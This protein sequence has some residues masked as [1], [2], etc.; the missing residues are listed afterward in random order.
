[1]RWFCSVSSVPVLGLVC[2][3]TATSCISSPAYD[4]AETV[5]PLDG[6]L[7]QSKPVAN[8]NEPNAAVGYEELSAYYGFK[9]IEIVK[10]DYNIK[11]LRTADF[12][13]DGRIDIAL[14]NN[15]KAAIEL[16]LQKAG[17]S[18]EEN[19]PVLSED[20]DVNRL[21][22]PSRFRR[23]TVPV[24][25]KIYCL[26]CGDLNS[27]GL[28]D[29]AFYGEPR[30]LYV[31]LQKP[32]PAEGEKAKSLSW[33]RR[34][35]IEINDGLVTSG[36]LVCA[37][38][39]NDGRADLALAGREAVYLITQKEDG[40]LAEPV[41]YATTSLVKEIATGDLNG[42][43]LNDLVTL[44][45]EQEKCFHIRFGLATGQ[46]GPEIELSIDKPLRLILSD[47]DGLA[48]DEVL[49]VDAI[50]GRLACYKFSSKSQAREQWPVLFYPL[51]V[52]KQNTNRDL[53]IGDFNGDGLADIVIS[54]PE[55][56]EVIFYRQIKALGLAE[57]V[58]FPSFSDISSLSAADVDGDGKTELI[59][60]S[61]KEKV[62]GLSKFENQ[63]FSF[64]RPLAIDGDPLAMDLADV[65][66]DGDVDCVYIGK[67]ANDKRFIGVVKD[68]GAGDKSEAARIKTILD[69][70]NADPEGLK[71]ADVDQDGLKDALIF[72]KYENPLLVRQVE[73]DRFEQVD[74]PS[75]QM[76]LIKSAS[77]SST[78]LANVDGKAGEELLLAQGNF[79]RSL[80][81]AEG[82]SWKVLDQY[83]AKSTENSIWA[84]A[85]FNIDEASTAPP[86]ILLL[87]GQKGRLQVLKAT[88]NK[89]YRFVKEL[90]VGKWNN[91]THLKMCFAPLTGGETKSILLFD[92]QKFALVSPPTSGNTSY[93]LDQCFVYETRIKDG[94]YGNLAAGD[95]NSDGSADLVMVE[96]KRNHIEILA[97][98]PEFKPIPAMRFK[99]FE[100]K[101]YRQQRVLSP[102]RFTVEPREMTIADVT[103]DG[104]EDLVTIIHD[105]IIVYPQD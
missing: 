11:D 95:I 23:E 58:R 16:L 65:D 82:K 26:V 30:G 64:P 9:E 57:P 66:N 98:G 18:E 99:V 25:Q 96:Y 2:W 41:K 89:T 48:G 13:G 81:F 78:S 42:D 91:A 90:D 28:M 68:V 49:A 75:A 70:L 34:Q 93:G 27:D 77:L 104:R 69:K 63:R 55:A 37:D 21:A 3:F 20:E 97:I 6:S 46:L 53:E 38:L 73:K 101:S 47:I 15:R 32:G 39:N 52:E 71:I 59:V 50:S 94:A 31:I 84:V 35:K 19:S 79:A 7:E 1:L 87:D 24:S 92:S 12:N 22:G 62:I 33:H 8:D 102:T 29:L 67:D 54:A 17:I 103:G 60:L 76:G 88:D 43:G 72:I 14:A 86:A 105:R 51:P 36:S 61:T 56:A 4:K 83:N 85:A 44:T 5:A 74:S 80:V 10:L 100:Q 45:K 40:T